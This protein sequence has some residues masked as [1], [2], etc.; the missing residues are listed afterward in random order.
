M[1]RAA[2]DDRDRA[3]RRRRDVYPGA[4][5][6]ALDGVS[7][8]AKRG[9]LVAVAGPNGSGK[10]SCLRVVLGLL[11]AIVRARS[12]VG[13]RSLSTISRSALRR[14]VAYLPQ[15]PYSPGARHAARVP[16]LARPGP[17]GR[18]APR[19]RRRRRGLRDALGRPR[20]RS[21]STPPSRRSR[22]VSGQRVAIACCSR[23]LPTS[24]CCS[25]SRTPIW[26]RRQ[27]VA[28]LG[29]RPGA[30]GAD[31]GRRRDGPWARSSWAKAGAVVR[32]GCVERGLGEG[33]GGIPPH[34]PQTNPR[35]I[36]EQRRLVPRAAEGEVVVRRE[37]PL[38]R[39]RG[40]GRSRPSWRSCGATRRARR[41]RGR[42]PGCSC[43]PGRRR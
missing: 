10:S 4:P 35:F 23:A 13:G 18:R 12:L 34:S 40:R 39:P 28:E 38:P 2:R 37:L 31:A 5:R 27:A 30:A 16:S 11:G 32:T 17:D 21:C 9:T 29:A 26:M 7:F 24:C 6:P 42:T 41:G 20:A 3:P 25:T 22:R 33:E 36:G 43:R 1:R 8:S 15:R 19:R 14:R